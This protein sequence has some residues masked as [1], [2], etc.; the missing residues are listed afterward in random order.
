MPKYSKKKIVLG[1]V[2]L[3]VLAL[4]LLSI[5][6]TLTGSPMIPDVL[7]RDWIQAGVKVTGWRVSA[8]PILH[9]VGEATVI[10]DGRVTWKQPPSTNTNTVA[11]L[12]IFA[13]VAL[14]AKEPP[15]AI[16]PKAIALQLLR[17]ASAD[18]EFKVV[19]S[20][21]K[22]QLAG[23]QPAIG[24]DREQPQKRPALR[25]YK[26]HLVDMQ[27][28][29]GV[30][31][32]Y[33]LQFLN[34]LGAIAQTSGYCS[35]VAMALPRIQTTLD[36][37][38]SPHLSWE[39]MKLNTAQLQ[40]TPRYFLRHEEI[41]ELARFPV[42]AGRFQVPL[43]M[44]SPHG[45]MALF[46][47]FSLE[48][49]TTRNEWD[50]GTGQKQ[51]TANT[52]LARRLA[53]A[54][55]PRK[56]KVGEPLDRVAYLY[57][58]PAK[59]D[60]NRYQ[61]KWSPQF[62]HL[63]I[64]T[65][66]KLAGRKVWSSA[67]RFEME[68]IYV[69]PPGLSERLTHTC[70]WNDTR[71]GVAQTGTVSG[72]RTPLLTGL[73]ATAG[74]GWIKLN[75]DPIP[76][77]ASDWL[78][79]PF[80]VLHRLSEKETTVKA[81][82]IRSL[83]DEVITRTLPDRTE[84]V[85]KNVR[86]GTAYFYRIEVEGVTRATSW[87]EDVGEYECLI[88]VRG[89][90]G[91][92]V[93]E[94]PVMAVPTTP[95][96]LR[97]SLLPSTGN[98]PHVNQV[99]A[100]LLRAFRQSTV[101]E[102][103]ER[104]AAPALFDAKQV[105]NLQASQ[106][107]K[108]VLAVDLIL[109]LRT[110]QVGYGRNLDVWM[111]DFRNSRQERLISV[112]LE[113]F[114][115]G[116]AAAEVVREVTRRFPNST[117]RSGSAL[118]GEARQR[119]VA[120]LKPQPLS[121]EEVAAEDMAS[122]LTAALATVPEM[123]VV[124]REQIA[125]VENELSAN[126][127]LDEASSLRLGKLLKADAVMTGFYGVHGRSISFSG[128][129]IEVDTGQL[130]CLV[131]AHGSIADLQSLGQ[132]LAQQIVSPPKT[133]NEDA[134]SA[135]VRWYESRLYSQNRAPAE[136]ED[137]PEWRQEDLAFLEEYAPGDNAAR[138][139][140]LKAAAYLSPETT[141]YHFKL[142]VQQMDRGEHEQALTSFYTGMKLAEE[143]EDPWRFYL[144]TDR[145]LENLHRPEEAVTLW[146]R[147]VADR[148]RRGMDAS[149]ALLHLARWQKQQ[150]KT[151]EA[152]ASLLR[153]KVAGYEL[154]RV[155][156]ENGQR[157]EAIRIYLDSLGKG[158]TLGPS[159]AAIVRWIETGPEPQKSELL[160]KLIARLGTQRPHQTLKA[161]DELVRL[162]RAD[163][164]AVS[165]AADALLQIGDET[166]EAQFLRL[167]IEKH[168]N[169]IECMKALQRL[170]T[171]ERKSGNDERG[172]ELL[173]Q[174]EKQKVRGKEAENIRQL[175]STMLTSLANAP[176]RSR[177]QPTEVK[178]S[179]FQLLV[180]RGLGKRSDGIAYVTSEHGI[181]S[182]VNLAA[183]NLLWQYDLR[184][185]K[186][187]GEYLY[188][189]TSWTTDLKFL[190]DAT[191]V[192]DDLVIAPDLLGGVLHALDRN[193]GKSRWTFTD[194]APITAPMTMGEHVYV[195]NSFGD[196][197]MLSKTSGQLIKKARCPVELEAKASDHVLVLFLNDRKDAFGFTDPQLAQPNAYGQ[198]SGPVTHTVKRDLSET[199]IEEP[200][201]SNEVERLL[202]SVRGET[203]GGGERVTD[204]LSL[205]YSPGREK[206]VPTL[207]ALARNS[208]KPAELRGAAVSVLSDICGRSFV[209]DLTT[210]IDEPQPA[211][212]RIAVQ[213]L[214]KL[215]DKTHLPTLTKLL[216]DTDFDLARLALRSVVLIAGKDAK[217]HLQP[218]L[219]NRQSPL[220]REAVL[221][222]AEM[223]DP[224]I[225]PFVMEC[226]PAP[227]AF[228]NKETFA[229][230]CRAGDPDA[231]LE[232]EKRLG[233]GSF[234]APKTKPRR[235]EGYAIQA[236]RQDAAIMIAEFLPE[237]LLLPI[238]L[239]VLH[240]RSEWDTQRLACEVIAKI[241]DPSAIPAL[242]ENM[243]EE[244][245]PGLFGP[246]GDE[247]PEAYAKAL[248]A[249]TGQCFGA[250][251]S[252]W[253]IWWHLVGKRQWTQAAN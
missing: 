183:T 231:L 253:E 28:E 216:D 158:P 37:K 246:N 57:V 147:A 59:N 44:H 174:I 129:L 248:E 82:R 200:P 68:Q 145:A 25:T 252:R 60:P 24:Y 15:P 17:S 178:D 31:Y 1:A 227:A 3:V 219:D 165:A 49:V 163:A 125:K 137:L 30:T 192:E 10:D 73:V 212:R 124:E 134:Q 100:S 189:L 75:W 89:A 107:L 204:I 171:L 186:A 9:S 202:S 8:E 108:D 223:G 152:T 83:H 111:D 173:R 43:R 50:S 166:R 7:W 104:A 150:G 19:L 101:I 79:G 126:A 90:M 156:E 65:R 155:Q 182:A 211:I 207:L 85:D 250:D 236:N 157:K 18:E 244:I 4:S 160:K 81:N 120:V 114:D 84:Y 159:Y 20:I 221:A 144:V 153:T 237:R 72:V 175:A 136:D 46:V 218:I 116:K 74:D 196:L 222:L 34:R 12:G 53:F 199:K 41:N 76:F 233:V 162:G 61:I 55:P 27:I 142:G 92:R 210:L 195:G 5:R 109:R 154:A 128:R 164:A 229:V 78:E 138:I 115:A 181:L 161:V 64:E 243:P 197:M 148:E 105:E 230:L 97:V 146:K 39:E 190:N 118:A 119:A 54:P 33:K 29:P 251:K 36:E 217:V 235:T 205:R 122:V 177:K 238:L 170:S 194:W 214:G 188:T 140:Q 245:Q 52:S 123:R 198:L 106:Q 93:R 56:R 99:H 203:E 48:A 23:I 191:V 16:W 80:L 132:E 13:E 98:D 127:M 169:T 151:R 69:Q 234:A 26:F 224:S 228:D 63:Q 62:A 143:K 117:A 67:D 96:P 32:Y 184:A 121:Q 139:Q 6:S 226:F 176:T 172:K 232:L 58:M 187:Y 193:T 131:E 70:T 135:L 88:P 47:D 45:R 149:P 2:A 220:R 35:A 42:G 110:R 113:A 239:K 112:P 247:R 77:E 180:G 40:S 179:S 213:C 168:A 102:L 14:T 185:L 141:A 241:G 208:S 21:P 103:L 215:G 71:T 206:S 242:I 66:S 95:R 201:P 167:I 209:P 249:L 51:I 240:E 11:A 94:C 91:P 86:N 38:G 130:L 87:C 22:E 133:A 225:L